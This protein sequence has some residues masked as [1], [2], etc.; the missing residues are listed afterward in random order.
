MRVLTEKDYK[1]MSKI[2][3]KNKGNSKIN[4][5]TRN[6]LKCLT[7]LSYSKVGDALK[8]LIEHGFVEQGISKGREK[9]YF[10]TQDGVLELKSIVECSVKINKGEI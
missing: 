8:S 6:E 7:D 3:N 1:V 9:T 10:I 2:L 4:G 5:I